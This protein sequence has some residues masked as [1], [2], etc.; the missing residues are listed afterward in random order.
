M[1]GTETERKFL[2]ADLPDAVARAP[3]ERI[4]QGYLAVGEDGVEVRLRRRGERTVL[5]VK[6]GAGRVR[7]EEEIAIDPD[8]LDRL[9]PL[10]E[11][12]RIEKRRSLVPL[13]GGL[14]AEVD[15]YEG[16]LAGLATVEVEFSEDADADAF[17]APPWFG[18]EVTDDPRYKNRSLALDG[19]PRPP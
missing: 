19:A 15:V 17:E 13:D 5:T 14:T 2:V 9:W 16:A 10:T 12:R 18:R 7:L 6:Q 11:G 4:D 8:V 1:A 3:G